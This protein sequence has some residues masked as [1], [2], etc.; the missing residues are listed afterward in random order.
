ML[1]TPS[2]EERTR[3][4]SASTTRRERER[5]RPAARGARRAGQRRASLAAPAKRAGPGKEPARAIACEQ[6]L[7]QHHQLVRERLARE[8]E[9][10]EV[11]AA[12]HRPARGILEI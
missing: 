6:S 8:R 1:E 7:L 3:R 12:V 5:S 9:A 2:F 10:D 11:N 4:R